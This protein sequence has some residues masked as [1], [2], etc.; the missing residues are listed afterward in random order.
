MADEKTTQADINNAEKIKNILADQTKTKKELLD[1]TLKIADKEQTFFQILQEELGK[2]AEFLTM[3]EVKSK[4]VEN[5]LQLLQSELEAAK[6]LESV[7][8]SIA[9]T[10]AI[11][12]KLQEKQ[13]EHLK[14]AEEFK[15]RDKKNRAAAEK[16]AE[17]LSKRLAKLT[18]ELEKQKQKREKINKTSEKTVA[19]I[20]K[21]IKATQDKNKEIDK[22]VKFQEEVRGIVGNQIESTFGLKDATDSVGDALIDVIADA[23]EFG[24]RIEGFKAVFEAVGAEAAKRLNTKS[25]V[26]GLKGFASEFGNQFATRF[27]QIS[28]TMRDLP[29]AFAQQTGFAREFGEELKSTTFA[30]NQQGFAISEVNEASRSLFESFNNFTELDKTTREGLIQ[31]AATLA[32]LGVET[33]IFAASIENLTTGMG[34]NEAA[35]SKLTQEIVSF[36]QAAGIAANDALEDLNSNFDLLATHGEKKGVE[37]FK[38]L[39]VTAKRAGIEMSELVRI[40]KQFDTFEGAMKSAGKLNFIL[41]GPLINSMEMLNAT[42][43]KRIEILRRSLDQ[44]GKSFDQ[45]GRR[46]KE[47]LA[48]TLGVSVAVAERLFNDKNLQSIEDATA[49]VEGNKKSLEELAKEGKENLTLEQRRTIAAEQQVTSQ[50][51][52]ANAMG[53]VQEFVVTLQEKFSGFLGVL[54]TVMMVANTLSPIFTLIAALK[55]KSALATAANT[56]ATVTDTAATA[57]NTA[58][59][60]AETIAEGANATTKGISTAATGAATAASSLYTVSLEAQT[61]AAIGTSLSLKS[62]AL[63]M[64]TV[65]APFVAVGALIAG[66]IIYWDEITSAFSD[67][68][69]LEGL[70][71]VMKAFLTG[72]TFFVEAYI[73]LILSIPTLIIEGLAL[74]GDA[75]SKIP[76]V[77]SGIGDS[78]REFSPGRL[79]NT[80]FSEIRD[81]IDNFET[82]TNSAP[83]GLAVVGEAGPELVNMPGGSQVIPAEQTNSMMTTLQTFNNIATGKEGAANNAPVTQTIN[84]RPDSLNLNLVIKLDEREI[85]RVAQRVSMETMQKGLEVSL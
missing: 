2:Q 50:E 5:R 6:E 81:S 30:L 41:G 66:L 40:G 11:I 54:G 15:G 23:D 31:D 12:E 45:L 38:K 75:V 58:A 37:I 64:F 85:A 74:L 61:A 39:A 24:G 28:E 47:A 77:P 44:S 46:G 78:I 63:S 29:G 53:T 73:Q 82:G 20:K 10:E 19:E 57:A 43:E 18:E 65:T 27:K 13:N 4:L 8:T 51:A 14:R 33:N 34:M 59:T 25:M 26:K 62:L 48:S 36:A 9:D 17:E 67:G 52:L 32:R 21:E 68:E 80:A 83:G 35:A 56:A 42:E 76:G 84:Q 16:D 72:L 79:V 70:K 3:A 69:W 71:F 7:N 55:T 22:T 49:A 60:A 1:L